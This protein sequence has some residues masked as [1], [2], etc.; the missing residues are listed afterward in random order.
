[1]SHRKRGDIIVYKDFSYETDTLYTS[2]FED[3]ILMITDADS[4]DS[5]GINRFKIGSQRVCVYANNC[6]VNCD[7]IVSAKSEDNNSYCIEVKNITV[8]KRRTRV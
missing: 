7:V 4:I 8:K 1:M 3:Q 5:F 6:T 2:S